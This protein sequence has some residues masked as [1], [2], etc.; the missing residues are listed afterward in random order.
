MSRGRYTCSACGSD[1]HDYCVNLACYVG[2]HN[3]KSVSPGEVEAGTQPPSPGSQH[4]RH[5]SPAQERGPLVVLVAVDPGLELGEARVIA[6]HGPLP[7][8]GDVFRFAPKS[9][10]GSLGGHGFKVDRREPQ[11]HMVNG[12]AE[13]T[14]WV[15]YGQLLDGRDDLPLKALDIERVADW[16]G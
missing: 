12:L 4:R 14:S 13:I 10:F 8:V 2:H 1:F 7:N 9:G 6:Y 11:V 3:V 5:K 15:V 16:W